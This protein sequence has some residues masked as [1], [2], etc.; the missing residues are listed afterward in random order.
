MGCLKMKSH[1]HSWVEQETHATY[2]KTDRAV[3]L[4]LL[5]HG[6]VDSSDV[7]E[8]YFDLGSLV[9]KVSL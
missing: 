1:V 3:Q 5:R 9:R 8:T 4:S 7:D 6:E 2:V